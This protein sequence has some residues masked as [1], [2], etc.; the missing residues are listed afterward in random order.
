MGAF[1]FDDQFREKT[2]LQAEV[3]VGIQSEDAL[4]DAL[5]MRCAFQIISVGI[6]M[7]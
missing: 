6:G 4:M 5:S 3:P 1:I 7:R 2:V